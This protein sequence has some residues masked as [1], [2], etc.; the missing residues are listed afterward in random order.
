[1]DSQIG[2]TLSNSLGRSAKLLCLG[3]AALI[4][5]SCADEPAPKP[6]PLRQPEV[7][8][9]PASPPVTRAPFPVRPPPPPQQPPPAMTPPAN[10]IM[11]PSGGSSV[12]TSKTA[13]ANLPDIGTGSAG[14]SG[15]PSTGAQSAGVSVPATLQPAPS[16]SSST[17]AGKGHVAPLGD[18]T[19]RVS[20]PE[21]T[22]KVQAQRSGVGSVI[23]KPHADGVAD[24]VPDAGKSTARPDVPSPK[25]QDFQVNSAD[26]ERLPPERRAALLR[27]LKTVRDAAAAATTQPT[28]EN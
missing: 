16:A 28:Q 27:Y 11:P 4:L 20:R 19:A 21:D 9:H 18:P 14:N 13:P 1:M 6:K 5:C 22:V 3:L 23:V 17:G 8:I 2:V 10:Q 12:G 15:Q 7:L 26:M 24:P 25:F